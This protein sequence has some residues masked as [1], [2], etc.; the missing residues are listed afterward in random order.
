MLE[1]KHGTFVVI[2]YLNSISYDS[3]CDVL[4]IAITGK[5]FFKSSELATDLIISNILRIGKVNVIGDVI[6]F[7]GKL[8][9][10]LETALSAFLTLDTYKY[11][12]GY[13]TI[14]SLV[15]PT[16]VSLFLPD[17]FSS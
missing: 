8:C 16:L 11:N 17:G 15:F 7:L 13:N 3:A 6:L 14:L 9:V 2:D 1:K 10:S 12:I 5:G 4:Q